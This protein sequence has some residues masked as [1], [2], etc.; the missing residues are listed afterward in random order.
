MD[1]TVQGGP[2]PYAQPRPASTP[3]ITRTLRIPI[4]LVS[5]VLLLGIGFGIGAATS[6]S[7]Q[8]QV[9]K[10]RRELLREAAETF[11]AIGLTEEAKEVSDE[12][13]A[14]TGNAAPPPRMLP[15]LPP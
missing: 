4:L 2:G 11:T 8:K 1:N 14:M 15:V 12:L 6:T 10:D 5:A 7:E 3:P 13:Q 9:T